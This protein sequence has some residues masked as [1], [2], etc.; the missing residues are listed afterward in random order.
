[1]SY[2]ELDFNGISK[3]KQLT[4]THKGLVKK[5]HFLSKEKGYCWA[6]NQFFADELGMSASGINKAITKLVEL[7]FLERD[8]IR[9][10]KKM[11]VERK[12]KLSKKFI[13]LFAEKAVEAVKKV[14]TFKNQKT[15]KPKSLNM[16]KN[17]VQEIKTELNVSNEVKEA[18]KDKLNLVADE[19]IEGL[20]KEH[21]TFKLLECIQ[22]AA[23]TANK[24]KN[25]VR[26]TGYLKE[27][28]ANGFESKIK[29]VERVSAGN[30]EVD[31]QGLLVGVYKSNQSQNKKHILSD[32]DLAKIER[33]R[34]LQ[35]QYLASQK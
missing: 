30:F 21:G 10:E 22:H 1:M 5:I 27:I 25:F 24:N 16:K 12:L 32:E 7:G 6:T 9:D 15:P 23:Y 33:M 20:E 18:L 4:S 8:I 2:F 13:K 35:A 19:V 11:V 3:S 26:S 17:N 28:F 31:E 14:A 29:R 34:Q